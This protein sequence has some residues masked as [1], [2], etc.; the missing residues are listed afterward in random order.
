LKKGT[1]EFEQTSNGWFEV[2]GVGCAK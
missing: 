1:N 2:F